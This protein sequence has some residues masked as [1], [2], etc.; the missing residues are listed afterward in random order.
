[1]KYLAI[2]AVQGAMFLILLAACV[3]CQSQTLPDAPSASSKLQ[4]DS[5]LVTRS[6]GETLTGKGSTPFWIAH[7]IFFAATVF[8]IEATHQGLAH[9]QCVENSVDMP[10]PSRGHL[11]RHD[12][13]FFAGFTV[14]DLLLRKAG[15]PIAPYSAAAV[16]TV[17]H[18]RGGAKWL[19]G[20]Y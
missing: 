4:A 8:D 18:A 6:W 20:C 13:M 5:R 15:V 14:A 12:M 9:H 16:G 17:V 19:T 10:Y 3:Q 11:Y 2:A 1:M 7:G